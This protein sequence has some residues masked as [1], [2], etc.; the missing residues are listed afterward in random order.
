MPVVQPAVVMYNF[1]EGLF[2]RHV[3]GLW[4]MRMFLKFVEDLVGQFFTLMVAC[5]WSSIPCTSRALWASYYYF[6]VVMQWISL[7]V[8]YLHAHGGVVQLVEYALHFE[9]MVRQLL[10]YLGGHAVD[11]FARRL[12]VAHG[13]GM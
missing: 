8:V 4:L 10:L 1:V 6:L 2:A 13:G 5:S 9:G 7:L 11:L 3:L 12:L